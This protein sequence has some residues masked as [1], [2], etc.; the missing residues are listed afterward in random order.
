M[1]QVATFLF[2][3]MSVILFS[4]CVSKNVQVTLLPEEN[5][6]TGVIA[7]ADSKGEKHTIDQA[8]EALD[9]SQKGEIA[10]KQETQE[11]VSVKY[12]EVLNALPP[13]P[14]SYLFFY[15]FDSAILDAKQ[16]AELKTIAQAIRDKGI[17]E[18]IC[19]GHSDSAGDKEYN[20]TLSL[21]RAQ[22]VADKLMVYGIAKSLIQLKYYG[23]ADP[24][25]PTTN[26]KPN[27]K[28]RRVEIILK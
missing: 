10:S 15:S 18:V 6:K 7:I 22:N 28:N 2:T 21:L 5:G 11:S 3:C 20:K 9:I 25:V 16:L 8:Y 1:K 26:N 27:A 13:K 4:G 23:D 24:L 14:Q 19:I 17:V 12:A